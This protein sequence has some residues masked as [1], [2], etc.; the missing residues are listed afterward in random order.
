MFSCPTGLVGLLPP[1]HPQSKPYILSL[2]H[3]FDI[4]E[5]ALVLTNWLLNIVG[6]K[7]LTVYSHL[8]TGTN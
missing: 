5:L 8:K 2:C 7:R 6:S 1:L 3:K 4:K